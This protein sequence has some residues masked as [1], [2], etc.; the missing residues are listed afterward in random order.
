MMLSPEPHSTRPVVVASFSNGWSGEV[1]KLSVPGTKCIA[2]RLGCTA[3][4]L[5]NQGARTSDPAP[6]MATVALS[7]A[8]NKADSFVEQFQTV[9]T[10]DISDGGQVAALT[11]TTH[12]DHDEPGS[13]L[14]IINPFIQSVRLPAGEKDKHGEALAEV[15]IQ[16]QDVLLS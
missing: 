15:I 4:M 7:I 2:E 14:Q 12:G 5:R 13:R 6:Q 8:V 11:I 9:F 16:A 3:G 1:E 10:T